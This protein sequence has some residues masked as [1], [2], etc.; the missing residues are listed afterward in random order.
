METNGE[1]KECLFECENNSTSVLPNLLDLILRII[2]K[3]GGDL[4]F[5]GEAQKHEYIIPSLYTV[6]D[7]TV[8]GSENYYRYLFSELGRDDYRESTSLIRLLTEIRHYEG[9]TRM[10]DIS[11][12]PLTAIF[13]AVEKYDGED[14]KDGVIY[15]FAA[16]PVKFDTGHTIAIKAALNLIPQDVI[17]RFML[18]CGR[19]LVKNAISP[20][21]VPEEWRKK[22]VDAVHFSDASNKLAV[23][24]FL[25]LLNQRA[26][27]KET[28][29]YPFA[30]YDDLSKAHIFISSMNTVRIQ[31]Q[32]GAFIYPA[33]NVVNES[34]KFENMKKAVHDSICKLLYCDNEIGNMIRIPKQYKKQIRKE[35]FQI[36]IDEGFLYSDIKHQSD[37]LKKRTINEI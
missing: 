25:E 1:L 17:D 8:N 23:L 20:S 12:N 5:R 4:Y 34:N 16:N 15:M 30:I 26:R 18:A 35:L 19:E 3:S 21:D 14:G 11:R 9:L 37:V 27:V 22:P 32:R 13:N 28:L 29:K 2:S 33:F 36:G 10:L 24:L 31:R 6:E 7:L